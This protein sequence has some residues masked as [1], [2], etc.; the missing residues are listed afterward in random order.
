MSVKAFVLVKTEPKSTAEVVK[1]LKDQKTLSLTSCVTGKF[2][3][4]LLQ[5]AETPAALASLNLN[6]LRNIPGVCDLHTLF[7]LQDA[8][9]STPKP[10]TVKAALKAFVLAKVKPESARTVLQNIANNPQ[11]VTAAAVAGEYDVAAL[12][13]ANSTQELSDTI[14]K[15][16]TQSGIQS[17]ETLVVAE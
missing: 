15:F 10:V 1:T 11:T 8:T 5:E 12:V 14:Q 2:D 17:T 3:A 4:V 13:Q 7:V 6:T 16:R 9:S